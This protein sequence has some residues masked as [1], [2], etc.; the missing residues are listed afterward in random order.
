MAGPCVKA[1]STAPPS[2]G[3]KV[4]TGAVPEPRTNT[5]PDSNNGGDGELV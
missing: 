3:W 5:W 1:G 4:E 2:Q